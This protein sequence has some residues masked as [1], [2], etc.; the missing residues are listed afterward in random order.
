MLRDLENLIQ[1]QEIDLKI[2]EQELA[3]E[4]LPAMVKELE[5]TVEKVKQTMEAAASKADEAEKELGML[6]EQ[7]LQAQTGLERSQDPAQFDQNQ[8]GIRCGAC[9]DRSAEKHHSYVRK[10]E[11]KAR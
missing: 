6:G 2:H 9:R 5:Q 1:L 4:L 8:P 3:K 10:P 7:A 11:K